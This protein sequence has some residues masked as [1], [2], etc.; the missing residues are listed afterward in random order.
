M[1]TRFE[2]IAIEKVRANKANIRL[3][4]GDL[5]RLTEEIRTMGVVSPVVVYPHPELEG[6]FL[7]KDGHRRR[8][9]SINA[10]KSFLPCIVEDAPVRGEMDDVE[11]ML[12]TGRNHLALSVL[13]EAQGFQR[14]LDLGLNESTIGKKFKK[15]KS[16][17]IAK[18]RVK[19]SPEAVQQAYGFGRL[20][21]E[22]VK[23]LQELEDSG[24][25]GLYDRVVESIEN[26]DKRFT[27]DLE[28]TI[29]RAEQEQAKAVLQA[30]MEAIGAP[31]APD[32]VHGSNKWD[33]V[34]DVEGEE[35]SDEEHVAAGHYWTT[36]YDGSRT[37][38]FSP[39]AVARPD[40][41]EAEKAE[42][43][44]LRALNAELSISYP[45][46]RQFIANQIR[47][48]DGAG[49]DAD[50][51]LLFDLL[52]GDITKMDDETLGDISGIHK[53]ADADGYV[54]ENAWRDRVKAVLQKM[55]WRQLARA[56]TY[57][58]RKD[59]DRQLRFAKSFDRTVYDWSNRRSWLEQVQTHFGYRFDQA[60]QDVLELF[61]TKGGSYSSRNLTEGTNRRVEED[62]TVIKDDGAEQ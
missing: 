41:S 20:D 50:K 38:W 45:V 6:D 4:L 1:A 61:K 30:R 22:G 54:E 8:Q 57:G 58:Q 44:R 40:I 51:E 59:T 19:R 34:R 27:L 36:S 62:V 43:Q 23:K 12:T 31:T 11:A 29:A 35:L 13:E 48:K 14:L 3:D 10:G 24:Q 16:E 47:S 37:Y 52:W 55:S 7:V 46:R 49:E 33:R 32:D 42:K 28:R 26:G 15:P 39:L 9:A 25:G 53:P 2:E 17:I 18:A 60:E 56:A 5:E 21:L